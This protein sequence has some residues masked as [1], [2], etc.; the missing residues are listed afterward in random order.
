MRNSIAV[1]NTKGGVGKSTLVLALAE[2]ISAYHG[3]NVLVIDSDAQASVSSM[4]MSVSS[5]YK[6]QSDGATIVDYLHARVLKGQVID[7][8][9]YIVRNVSDVDDARS[10]FLLPSDMQLTLLEREVSKENLHGRLREVIGEL[11]N[12][13]RRVFD[14]V[15]IDCPPGLS[16]LTECWLREA[17]FHVSPTKADYVSV[18]GLEVFRRFKALNPEMGFAENLGVI[19]NLKEATSPSDE[20]YHRWLES[21]PDNACFTQAIPRMSALQ[22]A[23]NFQSYERSYFA[24]YPGQVGSAVR[25]LTEEVLARLAQRTG[26]ASETPPPP[27]Q[28]ASVANA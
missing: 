20:E 10:L 23:A 19:V 9:K 11:L 6:L 8:P 3:K 13:V 18:C 4:L 28:H 17:D 2:T 7:W 24:K 22:D 25:A 26:A 27:P 1:M 16:V 14:I 15:L 21:N 5:L 12:G